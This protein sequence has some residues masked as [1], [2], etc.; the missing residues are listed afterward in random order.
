MIEWRWGLTPLAQRDASTSPHD[1]GNLATALDFSRPVT[2]VAKLPVLPPFTPVACAPSSTS[3]TEPA[4]IQPASFHR[5]W[6]DVMQ[7]EVYRAWAQA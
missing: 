5:S 2:K 4:G 3:T 6:D 1:P 7:S